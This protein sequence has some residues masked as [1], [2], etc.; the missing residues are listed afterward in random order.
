MST[1]KHYYD[2]ATGLNA[3][4]SS[5]MA[6]W[7]LIRE[8]CKRLGHAIPLLKDLVTREE[9]DRIAFCD[10]GGTRFTES[11]GPVV[12]D[13]STVPPSFDPKEWGRMIQD[14]G[15]QL[16]RSATPW[17]EFSP[18]MLKDGA[19]LLIRISGGEHIHV[20][21]AEVEP[22]V[23]LRSAWNDEI[24]HIVPLKEIT[25]AFVINPVKDQQL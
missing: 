11:C 6:C 19:E 25:H 4:A 7:Q 15:I 8:E 21:V 1:E 13:L 14:E 18:D 3:K 16:S 23:V 5:R 24:V 9:L 12:L 10:G 20:H 17:V 2:P 22:K